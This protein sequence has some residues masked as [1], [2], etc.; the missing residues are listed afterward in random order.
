MHL[1]FS[2]KAKIEQKGNSIAKSGLNRPSELI[3][4]LFVFLGWRCV[5]FPDFA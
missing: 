2:I 1:S 5:P 4:T 3:I